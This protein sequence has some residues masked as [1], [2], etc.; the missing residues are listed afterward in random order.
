MLGRSPLPETDHAIHYL[1][2]GHLNLNKYGF[3]QTLPSDFGTK[4]GA[5][6]CDWQNLLTPGRNGKQLITGLTIHRVTGRKDFI[7]M[8]H[9]LKRISKHML[10]SFQ[11]TQPSI[12]MMAC[13]TH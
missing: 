12:I 2:K 11:Y 10:E 4:I 6:A 1:V 9:K 3:A 13:K 8:L 5:M 7:Q